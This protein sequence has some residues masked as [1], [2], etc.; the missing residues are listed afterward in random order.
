MKK[1]ISVISIIAVLGISFAAVISAS[2]GISGYSLGDADRDGSVS[3]L[4]VTLLQTYM[5]GESELDEEQLRL[6]DVN[7]DGNVTINDV[8]YIQSYMAG[9]IDEFPN[10]A[11][12]EPTEEPTT[13]SVDSEGYY[14]VVVKP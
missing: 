5:V 11:P 3:I 4:D 1:V 7:R 14:N 6:A 13:L 12:T 8:T 9:S 10:E 2:A